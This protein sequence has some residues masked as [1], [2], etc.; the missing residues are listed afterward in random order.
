MTLQNALA[1]MRSHIQ[2]RQGRTN[3]GLSAAI[4]HLVEHKGFDVMFPAERTDLDV[5]DQ[6]RVHC[7]WR[8]LEFPNGDSQQL[9]AVSY[10]LEGRLPGSG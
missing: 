5:S 3:R 6:K 2:K 9:W 1:T 8:R 4:E 7:R 10:K